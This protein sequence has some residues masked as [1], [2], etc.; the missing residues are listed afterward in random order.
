M[1]EEKALMENDFH[2]FKEVN[3]K[4]LDEHHKEH[5]DS[6]NIGTSEG[7]EIWNNG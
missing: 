2:F 1:N 6:Q 3:K 5:K 7:E 4:L